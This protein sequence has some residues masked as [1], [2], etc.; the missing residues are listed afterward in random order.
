MAFACLSSRCGSSGAR[1]GHRSVEVGPLSWT[2]I[3]AHTSTRGLNNE[4]CE[5]LACLSLVS[6]LLSD[7]SHDSC[8]NRLDAIIEFSESRTRCRKSPE[9]RSASEMKAWS[10]FLDPTL[11]TSSTIV[12]RTAQDEKIVNRVTSKIGKAVGRIQITKVDC[13][14]AMTRGQ[15]SSPVVVQPIA[16]P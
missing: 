13:D 2:S 10:G 4:D 15:D 14:R 1:N 3:F 7:V 12:A 5:R 6:L 9:I 16:S 8:M 11:K